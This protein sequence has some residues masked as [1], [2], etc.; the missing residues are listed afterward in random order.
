MER[1]FLLGTESSKRKKYKPKQKYGQ[2]VG[3][4]NAFLPLFLLIE[5]M[6]LANLIYRKHNEKI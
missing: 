3:T 4:K 6:M 1:F 5:A 2:N